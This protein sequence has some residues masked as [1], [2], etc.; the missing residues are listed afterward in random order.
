MAF[1][2]KNNKSYIMLSMPD[3]SYRCFNNGV[4]YDNLDGFEDINEIV[5]DKVEKLK[6]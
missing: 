6:N 2:G 3:N 5:I 4:I 1:L